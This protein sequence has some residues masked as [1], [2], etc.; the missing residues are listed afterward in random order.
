MKLLT[1]FNC[2]LSTMPQVQSLPHFREVRPSSNVIAT[3]TKSH[4]TGIMFTFYSP[5][6]EDFHVV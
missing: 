1:T 6:A 5:R 3:L 4:G 2:E